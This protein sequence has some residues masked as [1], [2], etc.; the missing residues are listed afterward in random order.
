MESMPKFCNFPQCFIEKAKIC[1]R[2]SLALDGSNF[3]T[4]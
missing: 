3:W 4:N 1:C 2:V